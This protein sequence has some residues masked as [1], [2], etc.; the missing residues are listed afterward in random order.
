MEECGC[1]W[2][3]EVGF[4]L[5]VPVA[6]EAPGP[7]GVGAYPYAVPARR[8]RNITQLLYCNRG[9]REGWCACAAAGDGAVHGPCA[10]VR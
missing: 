2:R 1:S 9:K 6:P 3:M 5:A 10:V 4:C 7:Q 8:L